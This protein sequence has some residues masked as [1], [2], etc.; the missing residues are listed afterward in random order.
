LISDAI[1]EPKSWASKLD[2]SPQTCNWYDRD[3]LQVNRNGYPIR[4]FHI[5]VSAASMDLNRESITELMNH[6]C[7][8]VTNTPRNTEVLSFDEGAP[9]WIEGNIVWSDVVGTTKALNMLRYAIG[10]PREGFF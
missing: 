2:I 9:S 4:I 7:R 6:I 5:L 3:I 10:P 1:K 8:M